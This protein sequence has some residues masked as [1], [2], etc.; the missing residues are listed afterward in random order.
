MFKGLNNLYVQEPWQQGSLSNHK[1]RG[2]QNADI[3]NYVESVPIK[4]STT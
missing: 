1:E 4:E 3:Q 2:E